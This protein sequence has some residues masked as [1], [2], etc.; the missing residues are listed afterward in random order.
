MYVCRVRVVGTFVYIY[1]VS[2]LSYS[3]TY[4]GNMLSLAVSGES[5]I[6]NSTFHQSLGD[7]KNRCDS[8][9]QELTSY[10]PPPSLSV[11]MVGLGYSSSLNISIA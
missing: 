5:K 9:Q 4:L 2:V 3:E 1:F 8:L 11:A 10:G 6:A 7:L